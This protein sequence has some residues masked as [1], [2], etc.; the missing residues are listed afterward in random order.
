MTIYKT[1]L[2]N[3]KNKGIPGPKYAASIGSYINL[4]YGY[5]PTIL[6]QH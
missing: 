4:S 5:L 6:P 3:A 1:D 2:K